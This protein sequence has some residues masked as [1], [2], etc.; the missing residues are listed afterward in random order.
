VKKLKA[1]IQYIPQFF[2]VNKIKMR[3]PKTM[4]ER[5]QRWVDGVG[6]DSVEVDSTA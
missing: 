1:A 3:M 4:L 6:P 5:V 2:L